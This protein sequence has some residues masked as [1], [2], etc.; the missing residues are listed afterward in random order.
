[1]VWLFFLAWEPDR[2]DVVESVS[3][4]PRV[5]SLAVCFGSSEI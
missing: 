3:H 2:V 5:L 1:V 4:L